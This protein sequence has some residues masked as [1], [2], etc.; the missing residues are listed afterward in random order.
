LNIDD[1]SFLTCKNSTF[2]FVCDREA[3]AP[4][5]QDQHA[6]FGD[7]A[8]SGRRQ[9]AGSPP[10]A[11]RHCLH[12]FRGSSQFLAQRRTRKETRH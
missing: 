9:V 1:F 2:Q 4:G 12:H 6:F 11:G 10:A 8:F 3:A 7:G 5:A